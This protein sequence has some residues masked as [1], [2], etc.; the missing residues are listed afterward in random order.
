MRVVNM[1]YNV[2]CYEGRGMGYDN[3]SKRPIRYKSKY[4]VNNTTSNRP[5][6]SKNTLLLLRNHFAVVFPA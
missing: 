4:Y 5:L 1:L 2:C 3:D 6:V